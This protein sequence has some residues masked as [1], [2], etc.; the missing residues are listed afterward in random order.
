ME[1]AERV[2]AL[3]HK[4]EQVNG[5]LETEEATKNALIMPFMATV[6]GYNVFDVNEVI[7]E[8]TADIGTKHGEKVDYAIMKDGEISILI[9]CKK[10]GQ[11]LTLNNA[12]QLF[13]YFAVTNARIAILT[14]GEQYEFYTDLD[15]PN[16]MDER[17]FMTLDLT[18][19][20]PAILPQIEKLAKTEFDLDS[21]LSTA[22]NLKY[23]SAVKKVMAGV[24]TD[25]DDEF[26]RLFLQHIYDGK[27]TQKVKT[28]LRPVIQS[29]IKQYI[30]DQ[31]NTR[32]KK[33]LGDSDIPSPAVTSDAV[34]EEDAEAAQN[35]DSD[36]GII[37]TEE[38]IQA[39]LIIRAI[40]CEL[41]EPS[42]VTMRDAKSYCAILA[43][44]NNRKP[45]CRLHFNSTMKHVSI[46]DEN[47]QFIRH[48]LDSV[49]SLYQL[50]EE[51]LTSVKRYAE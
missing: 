22:E 8:F 43:D 10:Q 38:E 17:P 2:T 48:D 1:F 6:L 7:P 19:I 3:A 18:D 35:G 49:A 47:K 20:D 40:A 36:D 42:R 12:G 15:A 45:I 9:E 23:V 5:Q 46:P 21:I 44:D 50:K 51:I 30:S 14:N 33:A 27:I 28:E 25:I 16:K 29:G 13:R 4:L 11:P 37:T 26:L 24:H 39:F 32:L 31:V 41:I 34:A